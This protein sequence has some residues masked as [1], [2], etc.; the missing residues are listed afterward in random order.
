MKVKLNPQTRK[1]A[2]LHC[3]QK[4]SNISSGQTYIAISTIRSKIFSFIVKVIEIIEDDT[5]E[6]IPTLEVDKYLSG[7]LSPVAC[8]TKGIHG[9][10]L[11]DPSADVA[12]QQGFF[13]T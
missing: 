7:I 4:T 3:S 11:N 10:R 13:R 6:G 2:V 12:M 9:V 8:F 1:Q 5:H